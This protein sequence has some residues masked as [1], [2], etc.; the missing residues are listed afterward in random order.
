M[1]SEHHKLKY[2]GSSG[3]DWRA[4]GFAPSCTLIQAQVGIWF[5]V[6]FFTLPVQTA[7]LLIQ[8][9]CGIFFLK[10][11]EPSFAKVRK[12][13][14]EMLPSPQ[15]WSRRSKTTISWK[16]KETKYSQDIHKYQLIIQITYRQS[17]QR[18]VGQLPP[19]MFLLLAWDKGPALQQLFTLRVLRVCLCFSKP[20][21]F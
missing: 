7:F 15:H 18:D 10:K 1:C 4:F 9:C 19:L 13:K 20:D 11:Q 12:Y 8:N 17:N 6:G 5:G 16:G 2:L 21:Q 14:R 3:G